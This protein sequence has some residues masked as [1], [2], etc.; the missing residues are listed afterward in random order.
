MHYVRDKIICTEGF[1][2]RFH[3][4]H[5]Y[6]CPAA[7]EELSENCLS[8][9]TA[10]FILSLRMYMT[11]ANIFGIHCAADG[12]VFLTLLYRLVEPAEGSIVID[13]LDVSNMG[14]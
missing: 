12:N 14:A 3:E 7:L 5:W 6:T 10:Q 11:F 4:F 13:G 9:L 8:I 2:N 1:V